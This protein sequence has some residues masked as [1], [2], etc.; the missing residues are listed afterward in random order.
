[1]RVIQSESGF[2]GVGN[3]FTPLY[4]SAWFK[5][6]QKSN[7]SFPITE[8][9]PLGVTAYDQRLAVSSVEDKELLPFI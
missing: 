2:G 5:R 8:L 9:L 3:P 6:G 4:R 7:Q 1:V